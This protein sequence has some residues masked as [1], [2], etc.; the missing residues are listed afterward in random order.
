MVGMA[1]KNTAED[2]NALNERIAAEATQ[3]TATPE[4]RAHAADRQAPT[5]RPGKG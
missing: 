4:A 3:Q 5:A 1:D 2:L